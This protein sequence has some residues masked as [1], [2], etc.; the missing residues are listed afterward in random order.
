MDLSDDEIRTLIEYARRKFAEERYP[1][2]PA[3]EPV[4]Q[5]LAKLEGKPAPEL[6]RRQ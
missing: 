4:R 3:L 2:D 6:K 5:A 1:L